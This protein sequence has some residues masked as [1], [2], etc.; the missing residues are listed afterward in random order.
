MKRQTY[1]LRKTG[2]Y[3]FPPPTALPIWLIP[4]YDVG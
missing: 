2:Q 4:T 1:L 3:H